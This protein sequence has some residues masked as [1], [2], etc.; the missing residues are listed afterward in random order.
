[1]A[2]SQRGVPAMPQQASQSTGDTPRTIAVIGG[3][4]AG[5]AAA[6]GA[7]KRGA[8]VTVFE[9]TRTLG[10]RARSVETP[11]GVIDNGQHILLGAYSKC[12]RLMKLVGVDLEQSFARIPLELRYPDGF[13]L[14]APKL[15][16]PLHLVAAILTAKGLSY[17]AKYALLRRSAAWRR[18]GWQASG[19]A[20]V[21]QLCVGLP[22]II[23]E[24]F[25]EPLCVSALNTPSIRASAQVF[26][27]VLRD[28]LGAARQDSDYLLPKVDLS[29]LFPEP[30]AAWV[31]VKG[32]QVR[33]GHRVEAIG[34]ERSTRKWLVD[35]EAFDAVVI[36]T[37][38][39]AAASLLRSTQNVN[40][41]TTFASTV[42]A[43][44]TMDYAPITTVYAYADRSLC[45][46]GQVNKQARPMLALKADEAQPFQFVFDR[47]QLGLT[48]PENN[49]VWA[50][51]V[52]DSR[53][54]LGY[55]DD[56]WTQA[57]SEAAQQMRIGFWPRLAKVI[58]EKR[59][60][61]VCTP[62][63]KRPKASLA[64]GLVLAGDYVDGPYPST[65]EGAVRSGL[66]AVRLLKRHAG[67]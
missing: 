33:L 59:A 34:R 35:G 37:P 5:M 51:V 17:G 14:A 55:T 52:S 2:D 12:L 21:A 4:W 38:P 19:D 24:R 46:Q 45:V 13:E 27:N 58:T 18:S 42:G 25:I 7:T 54:T 29:A 66:D 40:S 9:A 48:A 1:M 65:L 63:V 39:W 64:S 8:Q 32:G 67:A 30:A 41:T 56:Q 36:A 10:G 23:M 61:F 57:L 22:P 60:T 53:A 20:T 49:I 6:V 16:A 43:L 11:E 15:A 44:Q 28:S 3:G 26:L 62:Q 31:I 50:F 47:T